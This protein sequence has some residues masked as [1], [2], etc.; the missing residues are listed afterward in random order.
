MSYLRSHKFSVNP[1]IL[2][3]YIEN[4]VFPSLGIER[5]KTICEKTAWRWLKKLG[6]HCKEWK[7]DIY[8]DGHEREDV[9]QYRQTIFLPMMKELEP[10]LVE[11]DDKDLSKL[12]EKDISPEQK[13]HCVITHDETTL[14]ANDDK[15]TGWGPEGCSYFYIICDLFCKLTFHYFNY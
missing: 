4:E 15:K 7:K 9:V 11:Y 13:R 12:V 1:K 5:K 14:N 6:W 10:V 3:N 2:K 8:V